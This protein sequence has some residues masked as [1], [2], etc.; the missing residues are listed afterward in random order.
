MNELHNIVGL[1]RRFLQKLFNLELVI[2]IIAEERKEK[3]EMKLDKA[4]SIFLA[5][6]LILGLA[7]IVPMA[8]AGGS[9]VLRFISEKTE[10]GNPTTLPDVVGTTFKV[11]IV[12][13]DVVDM[14]GFDIQVKWDTNW[15]RYVTHTTT[16]PRTSYPAPNPPSPYEGAL[17]TPIMPVKDIVDEADNIPDA[18]PGTL[19]WFAYAAMA[20][21]QGQTGNATIVV[22]TFRVYDQPFYYGGD[23]VATDVWLTFVK[24]DLANSAGTPIQHERINLCIKLWPRLF[25]YPPLPKLD[26]NPDLTKDIPLGGT[27]NIDVWI[28]NQYDGD[29][30]PFWDIGG[31]DIVL[32]F[33]PTLIRAESVTVDPD[34]WFAGF[35]P[36]PIFVIVADINNTAGTVHVA[37]FGY[38]EYHTPAYGIGRL[39]T[40]Q[41]TSIFESETY[42]PPSC[43]IGLR[44]PEPRPMPD[45][46]NW[47]K[48]YFMT[49][50][51]GFPHPERPMPPWNGRDTAPPIPHVIENATYTAK[52]KPPGRWIDVYTQYPDGFN[53]KGPNQPSDAFGPQA[54]VRLIAEVTYNFNPVQQKMV[55]FEISHGEFHWILCNITDENGIAW[56][57]FG[58]PWPCDN[59]EG[60][61]F[62]TW[63]ANAS[64]DIREVR[65]TDTITWEVG[66]LI[67]IV[68]VEPQ[69]DDVFAIGE[70]LSF[71]VT[72]N[73]ISHQDREA[74]F[75]IVVYDELQ[76][77][78]AWFL[79]GPIT[80]HYGTDSI[81]IECKTV[82][83]H[84]FVGMGHVYTN[85]LYLKDGYFLQYC[86][87]NVIPIGLT[88]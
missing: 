58:I 82:P 48:E 84:T 63:Y 46:T 30:S 49:D 54:T 50:I 76:V 51:A 9:T 43:V 41:F 52:F 1:D 69:P 45:P 27:F 88:T 55:T 5:A 56:V 57:E 35:W 28:M 33:D 64:V 60:R 22:F 77:P 38:G 87:Q 7:S 12:V 65:V 53:G 86:P 78:I 13:E 81:I 21:A 19:G 40:V 11:A 3:V 23:V 62:G 18:E 8:S 14:Y 6:M 66:Y 17:N 4:V 26:V 70:H 68:S 71:K 32:H 67:N 16:V 74:Y 24:T 37:F 10:L 83:K 42:P 29:L 20:P 25:Q 85:I 31:F 36:N 61:V 59:P 73:S 44:N 80:V 47:P 15:I 39:F 75:S 79:V 72:F 34:G 2:K